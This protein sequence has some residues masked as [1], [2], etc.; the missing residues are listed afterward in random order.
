MFATVADSFAPVA[1]TLLG[2]EAGRMILF[3]LGDEHKE[4]VTEQAADY[5]PD[6]DIEWVD[7]V[8]LLREQPTL[9]YVHIMAQ[10]MLA[11]RSDKR[12]SRVAIATG[13]TKWMG[14]A[15]HHAATLVGCELRVAPHPVHDPAVSADALPAL[16]T[17][18]RLARDIQ[19]ARAGAF[20]RSLLYLGQQAG[21]VCSR[22]DLAAHLELKEP[23]L[24]QIINGKASGSGISARGLRR[25]GV[26]EDIRRAPTGRGQPPLDLKLTILGLEV[27]MILG[28]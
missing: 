27:A 26:I 2:S 18:L 22:K 5:L 9:S 16:N 6:V 12:T 13:G 8:A 17:A 7:I 23:R 15:L 11:R 24:A 25:L 21:T 14:H 28:A 20:R 3:A 1:A 10:E 19:G 4:R